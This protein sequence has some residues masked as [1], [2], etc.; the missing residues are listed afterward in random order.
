MTR[1]KNKVGPFLLRVV[2][3]AVAFWVATWLLPGM[4]VKATAATGAASQAVG[5]TAG[6]PLGIILGFLF[7]GLVFGLLN[8]SVRP[9][10]GRLALPVTILTLGLFALVLNA[11]VLALTAWI[12]SYTPVQ[13][14]IDSF[15]WTA[16]LGSIIIS[17]VSSLVGAPLGAGHNRPKLGV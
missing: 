7:L 10:I 14:T 4:D 8:A 3:N 16:I 13:L 2:A 12:S 5:E 15:F 9:F 17:I 6:G 11:A 1:K